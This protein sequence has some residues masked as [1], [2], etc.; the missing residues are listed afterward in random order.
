[1]GIQLINVNIICIELKREKVKNA[2]WAFTKL[3]SFLPLLMWCA[4]LLCMIADT[5]IMGF[6]FLNMISD[7]ESIHQNTTTQ[8]HASRGKKKQ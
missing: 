1:M 6:S 4:V 2:S 5:D 7:R 3:F 8:Q